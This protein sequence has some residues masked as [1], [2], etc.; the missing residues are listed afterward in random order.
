M[1][2][3]VAVCLAEYQEE[4]SKLFREARINLFSASS[5]VGYKDNHASNPLEEWFASGDEAFDS[6]MLFSFTSAENAEAAI[7]L[8]RA[9]N[10]R[11]GKD[12]PVRAFILP[13]EKSSY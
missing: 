1:K 11:Q 4:V 10:E 12:F 5:V 6:V 7:G 9:Y 8:I 2:L 13:V 3:F